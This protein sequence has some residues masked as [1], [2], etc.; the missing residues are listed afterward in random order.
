MALCPLKENDGFI[1]MFHTSELLEQDAEKGLHTGMQSKNLINNTL[2][3]K[4]AYISV[5]SVALALH[6]NIELCFNV[7]EQAAEF[8]I[9]INLC[10]SENIISLVLGWV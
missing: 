1:V 4:T 8:K 2:N 10:T 5:G 6:I 7:S 3:R 9:A